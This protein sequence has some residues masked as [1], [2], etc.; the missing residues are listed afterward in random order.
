M[1]KPRYRAIQ[2]SKVV[3]QDRLSS[4]A[5]GQGESA[6]KRMIAFQQISLI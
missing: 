5:H 1:A 4:N 3:T 6:R 2:A